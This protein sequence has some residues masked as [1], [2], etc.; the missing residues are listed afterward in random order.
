MAPGTRW[1]IRKRGINHSEKWPGLGLMFKKGGQQ[2][3]IQHKR[4]CLVSAYLAANDTLIIRLVELSWVQRG[5][6]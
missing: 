6:K 5:L 1:H 2:A 4:H 3:K